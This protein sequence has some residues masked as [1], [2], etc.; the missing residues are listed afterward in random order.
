MTET[1]SFF[2]RRAAN[3]Y[4]RNYED[5]RT[6]HGC[7]LWLRR[8]AC[9]SLV[10][11]HPGRILDL[12]CGPGAMTIP[13][14]QANHDVVACD[15]SV[16]MVRDVAQR[17]T[18][19]GAPPQV[20]VA[21]A[22]ALPFADAS[23]DLV[24]T[25]GVLEYV[26]R[27]DVA[28]REVHRILR[29]GGM[30]IGT[31]SLPRRFERFVVQQY[32]ALRKSAPSAAQHILGREAF[33]RAIEAAGFSIDA[34]RGSSFTPFPLDAIWPRGMLYVDK[35]LGRPLDRFARDLAKTYVVRAVR[36]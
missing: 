18:E 29:A 32:A 30:V 1:R 20:A 6:R 14:A 34:R 28:L 24:V 35:W 21:D 9:L 22:M 33:D 15:L 26:P 4:S 8:E 2:D 17:L 12:G 13:L 7:T 31:M 27:L 25:T 3:Y 36:H 16:A 11:E 5:P 19:L 10:P 23:F